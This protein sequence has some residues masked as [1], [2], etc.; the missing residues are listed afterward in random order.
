MNLICFHLR[1]GLLAISMVSPLL[2][3]SSSSDSSFELQQ[4]EGYSSLSGLLI[5]AVVLIFFIL[6]WNRKLSHQLAE[7]TVELRDQKGCA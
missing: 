1:N 2:A 3:A 7:R 4:V 6:W 5:G